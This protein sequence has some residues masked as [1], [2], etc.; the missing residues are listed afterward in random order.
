LGFEYQKYEFCLSNYFKLVESIHSSHS[1]HRQYFFLLFK[2]GVV[3]YENW[4]NH[5]SK[6]NCADIFIKAKQIGRDNFMPTKKLTQIKS[7][8]FIGKKSKGVKMLD[9][10]TKYSPLE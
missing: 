2:L 6:Y 8:N 9:D 10:K 1:L 4:W 5:T 3:I 7:L